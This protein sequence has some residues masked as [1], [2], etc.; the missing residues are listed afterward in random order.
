MAN[1]GFWNALSLVEDQKHNKKWWSLS[2]KF[3]ARRAKIQAIATF[4]GEYQHEELTHSL[5]MI[6]EAFGRAIW[7]S[8]QDSP[9]YLRPMHP[10]DYPDCLADWKD[11]HV[12]RAT[13]QSHCR[14][15]EIFHKKRQLAVAE[16][17]R[18]LKL[19]L[20]HS[21][22]AEQHAADAKPSWALV[23]RA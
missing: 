15:I 6:T 8:I 9:I 17:D 1:G 20:A 16:R 21:S 3:E 4:L 11:E 19:G 18:R 23:A 7:I 12:Q 2:H 10:I 5:H 22:D 13:C 14:R